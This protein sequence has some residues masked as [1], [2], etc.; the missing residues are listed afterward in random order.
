MP[1]LDLSDDNPTEEQIRKIVKEL[2]KGNEEFLES[3]RLGGNPFYF[4][5]DD[6]SKPENIEFMKRMVKE[7]K[8][9]EILRDERKKKD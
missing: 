4:T 5:D 7:G 1:L 8:L 6:L 9:T 2:K 3:G